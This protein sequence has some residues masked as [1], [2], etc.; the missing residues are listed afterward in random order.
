MNRPFVDRDQFFYLRVSVASVD[1]QAVRN[2]Y[3]AQT[4]SA[5]VVRKYFHADPCFI[6][7]SKPLRPLAPFRGYSPDAHGSPALTQLK[8]RDL[9]VAES[10]KVPVAVPLCESWRLISSH[11]FFAFSAANSAL[12]AGLYCN[13]RGGYHGFVAR[14]VCRRLDTMLKL[15]EG[16]Q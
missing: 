14:V 11:C 3:A 2:L 9:Q 16:T 8:R 4:N 10:R 6:R 1:N 7:G 5:F 15:I 12:P 13:R